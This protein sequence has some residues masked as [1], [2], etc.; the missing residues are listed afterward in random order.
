MN[1]HNEILDV[2]NEKNKYSSV[3]LN[4]ITRA[5]SEN[6]KKGNGV[7]YEKHHIL[8]KSLFPTFEF[9]Y[10]NLV[11]LTAREHYLSHYLLWKIYYKK[12][13]TF[14]L[15]KM[16]MAL[17]CMNAVNHNQQRFSSKLYETLKLTYVHSVEVRKK[18]SESKKGKTLAIYNGKKQ[19]I[20]VDLFHSDPNITTTTT[21]MVS[22]KRK[23]T[24]EHMMVK[25]ELFDH[26]DNLVGVNSGVVRTE[27]FKENLRIKNSGVNSTTAKKI[28]IYDNSDK[29]I[30]SSYGDF[31]KQCIL[32]NLP[33]PIFRK[34]YQTGKKIEYTSK[35]AI[36]KVT[37][38]G[39]IK[40]QGWYAAV[41]A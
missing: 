14:G 1:L 35:S 40:Y 3:Y 33:I 19:L 25:K 36:T 6:R 37:K 12:K 41:E 9:E 15:N 23:D 28:N 32:N 38:N 5:L 29:L 34:S 17:L 2:F 20:G 16:A 8:P 26:D 31:D 13:E 10:W 27:Q 30:L 21:N 7:Y 39:N 4:I 24:G 11:H 18:M 22:A